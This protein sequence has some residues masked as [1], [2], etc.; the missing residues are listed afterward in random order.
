MR[1]RILGFSAACA[2]V[3]ALGGSAGAATVT[4]TALDA[5]GGCSLE[6]AVSSIGGASD[7]GGC[8]ASGAY[9]TADA[10]VFVGGLSGT[11]LLAAELNITK[12]MVITGPGASVIVVD[13]NGHRIASIASGQ[14]VTITGLGLYGGSAP[15]GGAIRVGQPGTPATL[16]LEGCDLQLN[17]AVGDGSNSAYGGA[18]ASDGTLIVR[19]SHF[20]LNEAHGQGNSSGDSATGGAIACFSGSCVVERCAFV[21]NQAVGGNGGATFTRGGS[22]SGGAIAAGV[23]SSMT[24][25][26]VNSSFSGNHAFGGT[27]DSQG[28]GSGAAISVGGA[29]TDARIVNA[30]FSGNTVSTLGAAATPNDIARGAGTVTLRNAIVTGGCTGTVG[31]GGFNLFATVGVATSC[32]A[33]G[34][35]LLPA[36]PGFGAVVDGVLTLTGASPAIDAASCDDGAA[37]PITITDDQRGFGRPNGNGCDVGA[38]E[39][40]RDVNLSVSQSFT[41]TLYVPPTGVDP[42]VAVTIRVDNLSATTAHAVLALAAAP[43]NGVYVGS[44]GSCAVDGFGD[45]TCDLGT[46][47]AGSFVQV[48]VTWQIATGTTSDQTFQTLAIPREND[49]VPANDT[50]TNTLT[51]LYCGDG[52]TNGA[53]SCDDGGAAGG[54]AVTCDSC[55]TGWRD[56][57][58]VC[59]TCAI[60]Y[61]G[62]SCT[63][64]P[65]A[66]SNVCSGHGTCD[67][68]GTTSGTGVCTC[69][70]GFVSSG[71][72]CNACLPG[73]GGA[74]CLPC[75]GG[76]LTPCND[77]GTCIG[78][79]NISAA[80]VHCECDA[81]FSNADCS[82]ACGD[83]DVSGSETCDTAGESATCDIDCTAP[84]CGDGIVNPL[85]GEACDDGT[86]SGGDGCAACAVEPGWTCLGAGPCTR[87]CGTFYDFGTS[88]GLWRV[89]GAG[90]GRFG[91]GTA[92]AIFGG[93]LVG[94]ETGL[95]A[96]LPGDGSFNTAIW[97]KVA[98]APAA[99]ARRTRIDVTYRMDNNQD[100]IAVR[101]STTASHSSGDEVYRDCVHGDPSVDRH[102]LID[103]PSAAL[104]QTRWL[105]V[106][107]IASDQ[108]GAR[109]GVV[110]TDVSVYSDAD[111]DKDGGAATNGYDYRTLSCGDGCVDADEDGYGDA[112]SRALGTCPQAG[113]DCLDDIADAHPGRLE[114]CFNLIDNDCNGFAGGADPYCAE[115]CGNFQDDSLSSDMLID[116][117]DPVCDLALLTDP[118]AD[119]DRAPMCASPCLLT[120]NFS[121]GK[122]FTSD[123]TG[124]TVFQHD[125]GAGVWRTTGVAPSATNRIGRIQLEVPFGDMFD[126]GP[127]PT[128]AV[129]YTLA[130]QSGNEIAVCAA[131]AATPPAT[132]CHQRPV[133][134][135]AHDLPRTACKVIA[136]ADSNGST[137]LLPVAGWLPTAAHPGTVD[138]L[139]LT[140]SFNSG[141]VP[142]THA[143][144][145]I[146]EVR[147]GS[148]ADND[149][150]F[151][152]TDIFTA[153]DPGTAAR[154]DRLVCDRCWDRDFDF[155]GDALSPD[156]TQCQ[157]FINNPA[158]ATVPDCDDTRAT[159]RPDLGIETSCS[160]GLDN[161]CDG[162]LDALDVLD[163]G[164]EDCANGI[165]DNGD[166]NIDCGDPTCAANEVTGR[167]ANPACDP[168]Y[169]GFDFVVGDA[170]GG[171]GWTASGRL[172]TAVKNNIFTVG[173]STYHG[174]QLARSIYGWET[175][176]DAMVG[177]AGS[178]RVRAWLQ[179]SVNVPTTMSEPA[180]E[181]VYHFD[182]DNDHDHAW[183]VCFNV[184]SATA[185]A[186]SQPANVAWSTNTDTIPTGAPTAPVID[187]VTGIA[188]F[189]DRYFNHVVIPFPKTGT[190]TAYLF[191]DSQGATDAENNAVRGLFI[192]R[193]LV[194]SDADF[195]A[196]SGDASPSTGYENFAAICDHCVDRDEDG[197]GDGVVI[198]GDLATCDNPEPDCD[199]R[200]GFTNPGVNFIEG[201]TPSEKVP[202]DYCYRPQDNPVDKDNNC[203][204]KSDSQDATCAVCGNGVIDFGETC[205]DGPN[206]FDPVSGDGCTGNNDPG[207]RLPCQIETGG[208]YI[209]E[210]H[211][212]ILFGNPA[213]QWIEIY[214]ATN[215]TYD[216]NNLGFELV[217][218]AC[219]FDP[220]THIPTNLSACRRL[221]FTGPDA[222]CT[223]QTT[224]AVGPQQYFVVNLGPPASA[225]FANP[226]VDIDASC[227]APVS[228]AQIGDTVSFILDSGDGPQIAD[229]VAFLNPASGQQ[230]WGCALQNFRTTNGRSFMLADPTNHNQVSNDVASNWCL[231][232][233]S[234]DNRYANTDRH[235]GSPGTPGTCGEF[236][237]DGINDDCHCVGEGTDRV[238][239]DEIDGTFLIDPDGDK[240]C[241]QSDGQ[242]GVSGGVDCKPYVKSCGIGP[243]C[244]SDI[245]S[246]GYV[247][248]LDG[249]QDI[250]EDGFGHTV[251]VEGPACQLPLV[252][253][254][255][256]P[257][258]V[259]PGCN[260]I[261]GRAG[262]GLNQICEGIPQSYP[263]NP[264]VCTD[265]Y[266]NDCDGVFNC[267]DSDCVNTDGCKGETCT[268]Q[269][270]TITCGA[271]VFVTPSS[272]D[273]P[274]CAAQGANGNDKV[275]R[276]Q[277]LQAGPA[278]FIVENVGSKRYELQV[279]TDTCTQ[280]SCAAASATAD[281]FCIGG[282]SVTIPAADPAKTY[283]VVVKQ[284][285][286]CTNGASPAARLTASCPEICNN[287]GLDEDGDGKTDCADT[288]CVQVNAVTPPA[289]LC[290]TLDYDLDGVSNQAE[291]ICGTNRLV[292]TESIGDDR[293]KDPDNDQILNCA[294]TDDDNDGASDTQE[295]GAC[296]N[297]LSKN[298]PAH[299]PQ[300][301]PPCAGGATGPACSG[302]APLAC[303]APGVDADCNKLADRTEAECGT[304]EAACGNHVDD[305]GDGRIDC[306]DD[307]CIP[308]PLCC[309]YDWDSDN[310]V[311]CTELSCNTNPRDATSVPTP[312]QAGDFDGDTLPNCSDP[313][314][315]DD[316]FSDV[317]ET[318]CGSDPYDE[319]SVPD[320]NDGDRQC[321]SVDQDDDNDDFPDTQELAC[322]SDPFDDTST[323][324]DAAHDL[325]ADA[326]CDAQDDDIDGDGWL[327][328]EEISCETD[329][330]DGA[331][332][333]SA[334]GED[335]DNDHL[336][337]RIDTDD[338]NDGWPDSDESACL[339]D[340]NDVNDVPADCDGDRE[341]DQIDTDD[342]GDGSP[343]TI[344][345]LC[346]TGI[347]DKLSKPLEIDTVDTDLDGLENCI[348]PDDDNDLIPDA[349]ETAGCPAPVPAPLAGPNC[350]D[351]YKKDTDKD[352][353]D[354]GVEDANH[355]GM[356][357]GE[358]TSPVRVDTD[359]DG[360]SDAI[361]AASCYPNGTENEC[362][363]SAGWNKDTDGDNVLDGFEDANHDGSLGVG[364]TNPII[365][366]SDGDG[367]NDG[368]ERD[369]MTDPLNDLSIP[370][371][372]NDN[373]ICDGAEQD[374]DR[375]GISDALE[376]YCHTDPLDN[377]S[378]PSLGDLQ[379]IDGDGEINCVDIDD[380]ADGFGDID[381]I[382]CGTNPR[383]D[384]EVP[385]LD[386]IADYDGDGTKNCADLDDDDDGIDD[387]IEVNELLTDPQDWDTDDDGLSDGQEDKLGTDPLNVDSDFDGVQD[388][389]EYGLIDR[390]EDSD[391]D[392]FVADAD[393]TTKTDPK[394]PDTDGDGLKDGE[395]DANGNGNVDEGEGDPLDPTDGLRDTDADGLIDRDERFVWHTDPFDKDTDHDGLDDKLEVLVYLT[396]PLV[397]DTDGGGIIDGFEI[398]NG[399]D[400]LDAG[401]D[402]TG[403]V[404]S[405]DNVFGCTSGGSGEGAMLFITILG[406]I[407][408]SLR[409]RS[410]TLGAVLLAAGLVATGGNPA[411]A[412]ATPSGN[413]EQF[414]PGGGGDRVWSVETSAVAPAWTPYA[415]FLFFGERNSLILTAGRHTEELIG[416]QQVANLQVGIGLADYLQFDVGLPF[417]VGMQS[418]GTTSINPL[419]GGG[420][421][422]MLIRLRGRIINNRLGGF[423]LGLTAGVTVP[424]G[425]DDHF[426]GDPGVGILTALIADFR[427]GG[428]VLS[429]NLGARIRTTEAE[430]LT[431][432]GST[433]G[434]TLGNELNYG[435]GVDIEVAP[436]V[437][438]IGI[439]LF[440]KTPLDSPFGSVETS[441]LEALFGPKWAF[442]RGLQLQAAAGIGLVQG[443][444]TPDFRFLFGLSWQPGDDDADGDGVLDADDNCPRDPEDIDGFA[445]FDGCPD[446]D[447]D[448]DGIL[449]IKDKCPNKPENFD[450][451]DDED[452]CPEAETF[453]DKD[454]DGIPDDRDQCPEVPETVNGFEDGDGCRDEVPPGWG[455]PGGTVI[456]RDPDCI[457]GL[458]DLIVHFETGSAELSEAAKKVLFE[459]ANK[460]NNNA[461]VKFVSINGH[462]DEEGDEVRN[463]KLSQSRSRAVKAYLAEQVV[464]KE[465]MAARG[466]GAFAPKVDA[467]NPDAYAE[468]RRVDFTVEL[469]G[470]CAGQ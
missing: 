342:D 123:P 253:G 182:G 94:W 127:A 235:F 356:T 437:L 73:Y 26:V 167:L 177:A 457:V 6:E 234:V 112:T 442:V 134:D 148:D 250:D 243:S 360:L 9:G 23:A 391:A 64:C 395:E 345:A 228:L 368:N 220:D 461:Y 199:D 149:G 339:T 133:C 418:G 37:T 19:D 215:T 104:G 66:P 284:T 172:G 448:N 10:I 211:L 191:F 275:Y 454:M 315:D 203:D 325:D 223:Y 421:M 188:T 135:P 164:S 242:G 197:Y 404:I 208:L 51:V 313:D 260:A 320:D 255:I 156:L 239:V 293:F 377:A 85:A 337:D 466:Y 344:E 458:D 210:I 468:N 257:S 328:F 212:P 77:N 426:R 99:D 28:V 258:C 429:L 383:D 267:L 227:V 238:C 348:D 91:Y 353:L 55:A 451:I 261:D 408:L 329:P 318:L 53:E 113:T 331:N 363:P 115:D 263:G 405:G 22:S 74:N 460:L 296:L 231:A 303:D 150:E 444:G 1:N 365:A 357:N 305:D 160:D 340:K 306:A 453:A 297:P 295:I 358:E 338:D 176:L 265:A 262:V 206:D 224:T 252:Q 431:S 352:G 169:T 198:G 121:W 125:A 388:G 286:A 319:N 145:V 396:D 70:T 110:V 282:G 403:A 465:K 314:D 161:D 139:L 154:E 420:L 190:N 438:S 200:D 14:T 304:K 336:C 384:T 412:Q 299:Y 354:D 400:P 393:P 392:V 271:S 140:I 76:A 386:G 281:S 159:V 31:S 204:G 422:D 324:I 355:D 11:T 298:N 32:G 68:S 98:F 24:L 122:S 443:R 194:R 289:P 291:F 78:S 52:T 381:E 62:A 330:R 308:D 273:F 248:C 146:E 279:Y 7:T 301:N 69:T 162:F 72:V 170:G 152:G 166:S 362:E 439:E 349:V 264:E 397:P 60:G 241:S 56:G 434:M 35:D 196:E 136:T 311:N 81:G 317:E 452:G 302:A 151:E 467:S 385:T 40:P 470:K 165:D 278:T 95:G 307:D 175:M 417:V 13:G 410:S 245:D 455:K 371:D 323:P 205:D 449:D 312:L 276:F 376:T 116:C 459:V 369:C 44:T 130:G 327:N 446:P 103:V 346:G 287:N 244:T 201:Q 41:S 174:T 401:D 8:V 93:G 254:V 217:I 416:N 120:W 290:A 97:R 380:D 195:D 272:A 21:D 57:V 233:P 17:A 144:A 229:Q 153:D 280:G 414:V 435:L 50:A 423:G 4:V 100:C 430:F 364:E 27:G 213:E 387:I 359:G 316:T 428:T 54:C 131:D 419:S 111:D 45:V 48:V 20:E 61:Y 105:F 128:V 84:T 294:D 58:G 394:N 75:P 16:T 67:G 29:A 87:D 142:Y 469:G 171:G 168:C 106:L 375:D 82:N 79:G 415:S 266:D 88:A 321:D 173:K 240:V 390:H 129:D 221:K 247:D 90:A 350:T 5:A 117:S 178:G 108:A 463:L 143:G 237:C 157:A 124:H 268:S 118:P 137:L 39:A 440:G 101:L 132:P 335:V 119:P 92:S 71:G 202:V 184:P 436:Q 207:G 372:L 409:R 413:I 189:N 109:A 450:G 462:A 83:G 361:E 33:V 18:I 25:R 218:G 42:S 277:P 300:A 225:G 141:S 43:A 226:S 36:P 379:D 406:G 65:G 219:A 407:L 285:G 181:I 59:D 270:E 341:C 447:N 209:T 192:D 163:C 351:Q 259:T 251:T 47:G 373:G 367:F 425:D 256:Q 222:V 96:A 183:G 292:G 34:A 370:L 424:T 326:I 374:T 15:E 30:S 378:T 433:G 333:P 456:G 249:C 432:P 246:D 89:T 402:F 147:L 274:T 158:Y 187:P 464:D 138:A 309:E 80:D 411:H 193:I 441:S 155:F 230:P 3:G 214:N 427:D 343:D 236:T 288:T 389:T 310:A 102:A 216:L 185:C 399:T 63:A 186:L 12:S 445:D 86:P 366:D 180:L 49:T 2:L 107:F 332:N 347:C 269:A 334:R 179:R 114:D 38:F 398:E 232:G 322:G 126:M 382:D 46:I 283:F